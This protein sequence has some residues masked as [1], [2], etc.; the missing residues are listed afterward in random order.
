MD[1]YQHF[2]PEERELIDLFTGWREQVKDLYAPKLTDFLDPRELFILR[3]II[4]AD[5]EV[6]LHVFGGSEH[7]ERNRALLCPSYFS[8]SQEDFQISLYEISY[9]KKFVS[10]EHRQVLGSLMSLGLKREKFGDVLMN[11]DRIQF[12]AAKEV[13]SYLRA[14][15]EKIGKA[16]I[17]LD[18]LPFSEAVET[19]EVWEETSL[20]VSSMRL[21]AVISA[22]TKLSRQKAQLLIEQGRVKVNWRQTDQASFEIREGDI[23]SVR[24]FGRLKIISLEGKT[25]KDK[26]RII[27]GRQ[28]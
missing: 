10:I 4:G 27:G 24:G 3:S 23:L 7:A 8:P 21:D 28:K 15:L 9:P 20:T 22:L 1:I 2:R 26:W 13:D 14:N 16:S 5:E 19:E 17:K 6:Q 11:S 12:I 18:E 25:K